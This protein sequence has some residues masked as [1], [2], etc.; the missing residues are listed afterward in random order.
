MVPSVR[1][2][3]TR[4]K[5][6]GLRTTYSDY[7]KYDGRRETSGGRGDRLQEHTSSSKTRYLRENGNHFGYLKSFITKIYVF[8]FLCP[9]VTFG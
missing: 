2:I 4:K 1:P 7:P 3:T 5:G 6:G 8:Y 9:N